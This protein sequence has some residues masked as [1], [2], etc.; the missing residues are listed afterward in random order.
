MAGMSRHFILV[1]DR[2]NLLIG[3]VYENQLRAFLYT[4]CGAFLCA[5]V[6][7]LGAAFAIRNITGP[8]AL[9]RERQRGS[10][11]YD[12][13]AYRK[14]CFHGIYLLDITFCWQARRSIRLSSATAAVNMIRLLQN[15]RCVQKRRGGCSGILP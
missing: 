13:D 1:R 7:G 10:D 12:A 8:T 3:V 6:G 5:L 9:A 11:Q 14:T 2:V 4:F 15:H